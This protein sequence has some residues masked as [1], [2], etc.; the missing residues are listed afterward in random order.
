VLL[1][2]LFTGRA[3]AQSLSRARPETEGFAVDRLARMSRYLQGAVD[4]ARTAGAVAL[5]V[6]HGHIVYE[7]AFGMADREASRRMTT[8]AV[9]RIASQSKAITSVAAMMLVEEGRL[10]LKDPVSR[11][12]PSFASTTVATVSDSG[13]TRTRRIVPAR[14]QVTIRDLLTHTSG[15]SYGTDSLVRDL[16]ADEEL[17]PR[18]GFGWYFA[19]KREPICASAERLGKL[20]FVAQPGERWVYGYSTDVLGCVVERASNMPFGDFVRTR[21][22]APLGM[23]DTR[24]CLPG[25][26]RERLTAVYALSAQGL[27]RAREGPLGQGDYVEAP[28]V[29]QSGGAG[30]LSTAEDYARFLTMMANGGTLGGVRLLSPA[31]VALMTRDHVGSLYTVPG[32]GFGLGFEVL[33]DPG[34]AG[35][36]GE[37]G[38]F[39]WGGAYHTV[40]W[41]DPSLDLVAVFMTQLLPATG[42]LLQDRF[43][44]LVYQ[45]LVARR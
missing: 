42:S 4:S 24:F 37:P 26:Q 25:A 15:M 17:G 43:R 27:A 16:Y 13:G 35:R 12:I 29:S 38:Q 9:F 18:A 22:T 3:S 11:Y 21:I 23:T 8:N 44:V 31:T 1:L 2:A 14:R 41:V 20:P 36:L 28:C 34:R 7:E 33:L 10:G 5:I 6:R 40:Y 39:G 45:A 30:L 19:D 32:M